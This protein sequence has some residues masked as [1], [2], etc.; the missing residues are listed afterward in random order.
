[1]GNIT[2][3]LSFLTW[4]FH[5]VVQQPIGRWIDRTGSFSQVMFVAG[6]MP[7]LGL[8]A[9]VLLWN[10]PKGRGSFHLV[11]SDS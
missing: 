4:M 3:V 5:A 1:M 11:T 9:V 6:L 8:L 7:L 2:G 10:A